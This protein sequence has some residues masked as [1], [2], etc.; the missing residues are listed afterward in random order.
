M[1]RPKGSKN[2]EKRGETVYHYY[3][4]GELMTPNEAAKL[5]KTTQKT[6]YEWLC[7]LK[8]PMGPIVEGVHFYKSGYE[9]K[10]IKDPWC[11]LWGILPKTN[12]DLTV[13]RTFFE[14]GEG[15]IA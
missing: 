7:T 3:S 13:L 2:K 12:L 10:L 15:K 9:Y 6:I 1:P 14:G 4:F 11:K 5:F 8:T